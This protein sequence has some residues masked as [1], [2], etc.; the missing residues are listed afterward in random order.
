MFD[1]ER[2]ADVIKRTKHRYLITY[3]DSP[4]IRQ[5]FSFANILEWDLNYGMRNAKK[6]NDM[7]GKELFI[8]NYPLVVTKTN[9]QENFYF[10]QQSVI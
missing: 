3:D 5:L 1:H 10:Q 6:E 9:Q 7:I 4:Y 2:F 8:S